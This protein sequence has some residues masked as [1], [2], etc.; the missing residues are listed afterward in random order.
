[1]SA[2]ASAMSAR[3]PDISR[4]EAAQARALARIIHNTIVAAAE[5]HPELDVE[6][7]C[8]LCLVANAGDITHEL[9]EAR[10]R[11]IREI[12]IRTQQCE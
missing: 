9:K 4:M 10:L 1:V 8:A 2:A 11:T 6:E 12:R 7:I 5:R 3:R